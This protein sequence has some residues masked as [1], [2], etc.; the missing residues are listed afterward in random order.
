[1]GTNQAYQTRVR[2][3]GRKRILPLQTFSLRGRVRIF[4]SRADFCPRTFFAFASHCLRHR[5]VS[6]TK[7]P[8]ALQTDI[9]R[10]YLRTMR[11]QQ[12]GFSLIYF[13]EYIDV[14]GFNQ[15]EC[16]WAFKIFILLIIGILSL[17]G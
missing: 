3:D 14:L 8:P 6:S 12:N 1:M 17:V 10:I 15:L 13:S 4:C 9:R 2:R 7:C 5:D 11:S 16:A